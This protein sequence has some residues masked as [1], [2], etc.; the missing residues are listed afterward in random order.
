M[1]QSRSLLAGLWCAIVVPSAQGIDI[2]FDYTYDSSNFFNGNLQRQNALNAAAQVFES[3]LTDN[4]TAITPSGGNTWTATFRNPSTG[5]TETVTDRS[6]AAGVIVV[7][8]GARDLSG[9]TLGIGGPGGF[10]VSGT[11]Q[12]FIDSVVLRGQIGAD[13]TPPTDFGPWGGSIAFDSFEPW[14]FDLD[15][16]TIEAFPSQPDFYSVAVHEL[17]HL[18]GF[19][20]AESWDALVSAGNF[21]GPKS[22]ALNG[23]LAVTLSGDLSHW[24]ENTT[25]DVLSPVMR[26]D[27]EAAMDPTIFDGSRKYFTELDFAGLD[28]IGWTVIPEPATAVLLLSGAG[29][30]ALRRR[31]A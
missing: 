17:A 16:S 7:Y 30:V 24:A 6:I 22:M 18:L 31:R 26:L 29:F 4:L 2:Q 28:D 13:D 1:R 25:S 20:T 23:G 10:M 19:G 8:A 3:R 21:N 5:V 9:G 12:S 14:Y 15:P 11:S 27:Q